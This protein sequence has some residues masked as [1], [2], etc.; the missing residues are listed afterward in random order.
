MG[1]DD[2]YL[3]LFPA[4]LARSHPHVLYC[5]CVCQ[6]LRPGDA[7]RFKSRRADIQCILRIRLSLIIRIQAPLLRGSPEFNGLCLPGRI[8]IQ[9]L[10]R[11]L[12]YPGIRDGD[13][14]VLYR[15]GIHR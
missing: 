1:R 8:R 11:I 3:F 4:R 15:I 2:E 10:K 9:H 12:R 7:H 13:P 14:G 5:F 6:D